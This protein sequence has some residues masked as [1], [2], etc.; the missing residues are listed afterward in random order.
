MTVNERHVLSVL[1]DLMTESRAFILDQGEPGLR[2]SHHRVIGNVPPEGVTQTELAD[3]VGMTKQGVGQ[4]VTQLCESGH[5][6]VEPKAGDRRVR[7]VHRTV[8]GDAS[9]RDLSRLLERLEATWAGRVGK[10]RYD[11][12][13]ET[14]DGIALG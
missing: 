13:R 11:A 6:R 5:L 9:I 10:A 2:A 1:G 4:F 12:F 14:L 3:R 7:V 8:K